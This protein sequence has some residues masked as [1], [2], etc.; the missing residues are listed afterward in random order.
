MRTRRRIRIQQ[1][2]VK[3]AILAP[4]MP[5]RHQRMVMTRKTAQT[6][7]MEVTKMEKEAKRKAKIRLRGVTQVIK[8]LLMDP[9]IQD[10]TIRRVV[11]VLVN[12]QLRELDRLNM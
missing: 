5:K 11:T 8:D 1:R 9:R 7:K 2:A 4:I 3:M 6:E 12:Q 10:R